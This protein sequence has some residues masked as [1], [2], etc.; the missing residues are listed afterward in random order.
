MLSRT[1]VFPK[2]RLMATL[3]P[4]ADDQLRLRIEREVGQLDFSDFVASSSLGVGATTVLVGNPNL[5]PQQ[6][7]VVEAAYERHFKSL[8]AVFTY[9]HLFIQDAIDR[10]PIFNASGVYD[11]PGN[12]GSGFED[13]LDVNLTLP[14]DQIGLKGAELRAQGTYRHA[15]VTDPTTGLQRAVS[16][17]HRFDYQAHFTQDVFKWRTTFGVDL[18]SR[19]TQ[20]NYRFGEI[21][22][23]KLKTWLDVFVQYKPSPDL[24]LRFEVD[25]LGS[26]G[27]ERL[28]YVYG[29]PRDTTGLHYVDDRRQEFAPYLYFRVRKTF[30]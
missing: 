25:N 22:V 28:L 3:S 15:R 27:Y 20:P 7:W 10:V 21:D 11:A 8:A 12:I 14:F 18:F 26:R 23:F 24:A 19:W 17:Q 2:P 29:G 13:D 9:R 5:I 1:L 4:D 6:D 16:G 30:N